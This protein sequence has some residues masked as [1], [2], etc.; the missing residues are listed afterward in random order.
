MTSGDGVRGSAVA[1][2]L[3]TFAK[4]IADEV[5]LRHFAADPSL[6]K[7]YGERG[8]IRCTEDAHRH[9]SYL[10]ASAS[11]SSDA[12]FEEY[13]G[14]AKILLSRLG[15]TEHHLARN[16]ALLREVIVDMIPGREGAAA[17]SIVDKGLSRLPALPSS[18]QSFIEDADPY[19]ELAQRYLSTLLA[20][21]RQEASELILESVKSGVSVRDIYMH[22]FQRS[23]YEIGRR[24]QLN[25]MTVAE[26]HFCTAATQL[27]M[28]QLYPQIFS[29]TRRNRRLVAACVG[30]DLHEIGLRMVADFFEMA[31]WDTYYIGA[32]TPTNG[33]VSAAADNRADAVAI[34][35]TMSFHVPAVA[36]AV[37]ALRSSNFVRPPAILVGGYPFKVDPDLWQTIGADG[38]AADATSAVDLADE[39]IDKR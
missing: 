29:S 38:Y 35:A 31:G 21:N 27:I 2:A 11:A 17:A 20:G 39:L 36:E 22:V 23:Q 14:W 34:S 1:A 13:V 30:G 5:T 15:L 8:R 12:L 16:L 9:L 33:L 32:N 18:T 19:S 10:A 3:E 24:W 25:E 6:E 28:S 26:E 4:G 37:A 7:K